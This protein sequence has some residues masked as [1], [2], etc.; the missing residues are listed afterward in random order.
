MYTEELTKCKALL[1]EDDYDTVRGTIRGLERKLLHIDKV[2]SIEDAEKHLRESTYALLIIDVRIPKK[3]EDYE[4]AVEG[5]L[6]LIRDLK[7]GAL[8]DLN[9]D[10]FYLILS[11]QD[12][13][14]K[15]TEFED[16][17]KFLG[18]FGKL[19]NLEVLNKVEEF[20][21]TYEC[22]PARQKKVSQ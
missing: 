2:S 16:D 18:V 8:G 3:E 4:V 21:Q 7:K 15:I 12:R 5:G 9:N 20:L 1:V 10:Q 6:D 13:S 22:E 19:M 11:A 17:A 14:V